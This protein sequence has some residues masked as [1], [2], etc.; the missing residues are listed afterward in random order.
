MKPRTWLTSN[1]VAEF[2]DTTPDKV[3]YWGRKGFFGKRYRPGKRWLYNFRC[4]KAA[5]PKWKRLKLSEV[6]KRSDKRP[7]R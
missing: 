2:L 6:K 7:R 1:E 3:N 4:V 5:W